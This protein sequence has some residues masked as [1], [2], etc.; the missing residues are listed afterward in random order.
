[1]G[2][3]SGKN[4]IITGAAGGIGLETCI[5]FAKEG[6]N[7]L[8]ADISEPALEKALAKVKQLVPAAG[9]IETKVAI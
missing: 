4:A 8:M 9:K 3:L 5:L 2:R 7:V 6:A 1:M